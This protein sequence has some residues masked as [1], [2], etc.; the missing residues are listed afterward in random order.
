MILGQYSEKTKR[1]LFCR[2]SA[3]NWVM[4]ASLF[5]GIVRIWAES[6]WGQSHVR[7]VE[8]LYSCDEVYEIFWKWASQKQ[9]P[10]DWYQGRVFGIGLFVVRVLIGVCM[11]L[12]CCAPLP[13]YLLISLVMH[14]CLLRYPCSNE[15]GSSCCESLV[16]DH[17]G[18]G[19]L[20]PSLCQ[21]GT[22]YIFVAGTYKYFA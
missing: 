19:I 11:V 20:V 2:D 22:N 5:S 12:V 3:P 4:W 6:R 15:A 1:E 7:N 14:P 17:C 13:W 16:K 8:W 18:I 9:R 10:E 21:T